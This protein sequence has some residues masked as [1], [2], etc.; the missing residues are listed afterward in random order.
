MKQQTIYYQ[1]EHTKNSSSLWQYFKNVEMPKLRFL[2]RRTKQIYLKFSNE[3]K[4]AFSM[5]LK[6]IPFS[7][8]ISL[9]SYFTVVDMLTLFFK[10]ICLLQ[11]NPEHPRIPLRTTSR[12]T[13]P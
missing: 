3:Y 8:C 2:I 13:I 6:F 7:F 5:L 10:D 4:K 11:I 9:S 1:K 12:I